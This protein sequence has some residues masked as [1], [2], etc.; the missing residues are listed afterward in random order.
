MRSSDS[1]RTEGRG[2]R[3]PEHTAVEQITGRVVIAFSSGVD[4]EADVVSELF[5]LAP[6]AFLDPSEMA[7]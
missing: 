4:T 2:R 5:A 6:L 3:A 1:K 7:A